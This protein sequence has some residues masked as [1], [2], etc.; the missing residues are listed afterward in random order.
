MTRA[1]AEEKIALIDALALE[2][3]TDQELKAIDPRYA[4]MAQWIDTDLEIVEN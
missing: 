3:E 1:E 2:L 4:I